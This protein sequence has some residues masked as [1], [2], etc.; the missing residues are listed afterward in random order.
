MA[1]K[2]LNVLNELIIRKSL[3]INELVRQVAAHPERQPHL[4]RRQLL[5][6][7]EI[8]VLKKRKSLLQISK[9]NF[10]D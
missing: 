2:T 9:N 8:D 5:L 10:G 7:R 1:Y 6:Y 4:Y 3:A